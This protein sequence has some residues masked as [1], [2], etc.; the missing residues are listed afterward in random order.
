MRNIHKFE[1]HGACC[2]NGIIRAKK[3]I[4]AIEG[5][6]KVNINLAEHTAT[7]TGHIDPYAIVQALQDAKFEAAFIKPEI[8]AAVE[9]TTD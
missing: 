8:I 1:L 4:A 3:V 9:S 7:V 6:G 5:S 2:G